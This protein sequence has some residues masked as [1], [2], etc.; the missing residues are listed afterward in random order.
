MPPRPS[1]PQR[2]LFDNPVRAFSLEELTE[3]VQALE[4]QQPGRTVDALTSAV[5]T[6]LAMKRTR[7][8]ADLVAEAIR[9]ARARQPRAEITGSRW[10]AGTSEVREWAAG[11]G[12]QIGTD[13]TIP[14]QAIAA[15]NQTHPG[16]PY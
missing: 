3:T 12:F 9:I 4:R 2:G 1:G 7:R 5:F 14:E 8:A 15:Y 6:E 11:N 16:R 10:Q 13:G